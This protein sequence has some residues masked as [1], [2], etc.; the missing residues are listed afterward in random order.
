MKFS[1]LKKEVAELN[2]KIFNYLQVI[3]KLISFGELEAAKVV[4]KSQHEFKSR[5]K[6]LLPIL[7]EYERRKKFD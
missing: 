7:R 6:D 3:N 4:Q 2:K 1:Q 5:L